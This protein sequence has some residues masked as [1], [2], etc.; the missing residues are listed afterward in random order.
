MKQKHL[1]K[2]L[3]ERRDKNVRNYSGDTNNG[4]SVD[5]HLSN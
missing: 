4:H 1:K 3:S 2:P 5:D